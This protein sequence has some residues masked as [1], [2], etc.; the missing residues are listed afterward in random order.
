MKMHFFWMKNGLVMCIEF[1]M[2]KGK[3]STCVASI[4][5]S[6]HGN[7]KIRSAKHVRH[8]V[9]GLWRCKI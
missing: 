4:Y 2:L 7:D 3:G 9:A 8:E 6:W 1:T 5:F